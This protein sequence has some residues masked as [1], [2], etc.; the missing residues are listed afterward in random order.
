M[1]LTKEQRK[2]IA[3]KEYEKIKNT[4]LEKYLKIKNTA[5]EKY[6]KIENPAWKEYE[7]KIKEIEDE[8]E[9]TLD[10]G[11]KTFKFPKGYMWDGDEQ[12]IEWIMDKLKVC[13]ENNW[14]VEEDTFFVVHSSRREE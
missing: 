5:L 2:K 4:A 1:K 10:T 13:D 12:I 9:E 6:L 8:S 14:T 7:K 3:W 11:S